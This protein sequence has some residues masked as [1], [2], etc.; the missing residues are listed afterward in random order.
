MNR[1]KSFWSYAPSEAEC[2]LMTYTV[3]PGGGA[4]VELAERAGQAIST[5]TSKLSIT[6]TE[7]RNTIGPIEKRLRDE[8]ERV[9][10][11]EWC[12]RWFRRGSAICRCAR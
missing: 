8:M 9:L 2:S 11:T 7:L 1:R 5:S 6:M 4:Y 3:W 12:K 10:G